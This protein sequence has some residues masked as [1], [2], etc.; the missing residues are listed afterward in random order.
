MKGGKPFTF[1]RRTGFAGFGERLLN[2][3]LADFLPYAK[4]HTRKSD[5]YV[6]RL[7]PPYVCQSAK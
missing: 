5:S 4:G 3:S 6:R 2:C 1:I 7:R